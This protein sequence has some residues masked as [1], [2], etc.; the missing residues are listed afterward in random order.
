MGA[1]DIQSNQDNKHPHDQNEKEEQAAFNCQFIEGL[2]EDQYE[3]S[4]YMKS[5]DE[6]SVKT[7]VVHTPQLS[8]DSINMPGLP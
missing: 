3:E 6:M 8:K 7:T 1:S 4:S 2:L 5:I